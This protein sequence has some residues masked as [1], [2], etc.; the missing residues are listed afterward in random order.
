VH[1]DRPLPSAPGGEL[2]R[3]VPAGEL[4]AIVRLYRRHFAL[5]RG[6]RPEVIDA[7]IVQWVGERSEAS[8]GWSTRARRGVMTTRL[9]ATHFSIMRPPHITRI[10][11]ELTQA[12]G[13]LAQ[14][15]L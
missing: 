15:V 1:P 10:A 3:T 14:G 12:S 6:Y 5:S 13:Q 4:D 8:A 2:A 7:P 9:E 11:G